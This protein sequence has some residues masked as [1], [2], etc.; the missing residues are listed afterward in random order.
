[1]A[2]VRQVQPAML[3]LVTL[4][5]MIGRHSKLSNKSTVPHLLILKT[6]PTTGWHRHHLCLQQRRPSAT[7]LPSASSGPKHRICSR[8]PSFFVDVMT[9]FPRTDCAMNISLPTPQRPLTQT[10]ALPF[11]QEETTS[12]HRAPCTSLQPLGPQAEYSGY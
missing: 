4:V 9:M 6:G 8:S 5:R 7:S 3:G 1:M 10:D 12:L 11:R 2:G